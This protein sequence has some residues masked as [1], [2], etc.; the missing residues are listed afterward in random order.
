MMRR[1][2]YV[3]ATLGTSPAVITEL[4]YALVAGEGRDVV[5]LE[6]WTTGP[7]GPD[8]N[9]RTGRGDLTRFIEGGAWGQLR[10][11]LGTEGG[12]RIPSPSGG[13][14]EP[15]AA[16]EAV[17]AGRRPSVVGVFGGP[18]APLNDVRTPDDAR[19]MD[20]TLFRRVQTL[21]RDLP[22]GVM[23]VGSLAGG[24]KTMSAG[25]QGAFSMLGRRED[26]LVHVLLHPL[27]DAVAQKIGYAVPYV[28]VPGAEDVPCD[29]QIALHDV[30]F[31]MLR[32]LMER[33][34]D[35]AFG[36][37][38]AHLQHDYGEFLAAMHRAADP[39][40]T[41]Q[42]HPKNTGWI[43]TV[44]GVGVP[45]TVTLSRVPGLALAGLVALRGDTTY[46]A[47]AEWMAGQNWEPGKDPEFANNAIAQI[48]VRLRRGLAP[49]GPR[50][51]LDFAVTKPTRG[52]RCSL[53]AARN[54]RIAL[55]TSDLS[56]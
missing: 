4:L 20:A 13:W 32:G 10:E 5:G 29:Q 14:V 23:L 6:I 24:R 15:E 38:A 54:G 11:A 36:T 2:C 3:L 45:V 18:K 22:A 51:L 35:P 41:L 55:E 39:S 26:R 7:T 50:N 49:L 48:V 30:H 16:V 44:F 17:A 8:D 31:P 37:A 52:N 28:G 42:R 19:L 47:L 27:V 53:L 21:T 33:A 40:A 1:S 34:S 46:E 56:V 12:G 9:T 43:Y 25:L